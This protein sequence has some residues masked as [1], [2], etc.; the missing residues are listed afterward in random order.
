MLL[1]MSTQGVPVY[2]KRSATTR[3][4]AW[5]VVFALL[6]VAQVY[7]LA[8]G[9]SLTN[10]TPVIYQALFPLIELGC[11]VPLIALVLLRHR[12]F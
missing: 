10:I 8:S 7:I 12:S 2:R 6:L 4:I 11:I 1:H 9:P 5:G 3:N